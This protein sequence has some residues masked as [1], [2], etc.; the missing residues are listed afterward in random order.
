MNHLE[1]LNHRFRRCKETIYT[2]CSL[3]QKLVWQMWGLAV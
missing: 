2:A 1:R 3:P